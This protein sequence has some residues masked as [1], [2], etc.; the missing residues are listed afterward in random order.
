MKN[1]KT[2]NATSLELINSE[3]PILKLYRI[4]RSFIL[5]DEDRDQWLSSATEIKNWVN[6]R[7]DLVDSRGRTWKY[8]TISEGMKTDRDKILKF[9]SDPIRVDSEGLLERYADSNDESSLSPEE[10]VIRLSRIIE[11]HPYLIELIKKP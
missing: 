8:S 9:I 7:V 11:S 4:D 10:A 2:N 5:I 3:G 1:K 6:N